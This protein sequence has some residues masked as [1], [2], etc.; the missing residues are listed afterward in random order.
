MRLFL[1]TNVLI[2]AY[3]WQGAKR[4]LLWDC[5]RGS[6]ECCISDYVVYE[7]R[8]VLIEKFSLPEESIERYISILTAFL[9]VIETSSGPKIS[10]DPKD[11][12]ILW[13][14]AKSG[15]DAL[16]TGDGDLLS[17]RDEEKLLCIENS[18]F[19]VLRT[20]EVLK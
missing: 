7:L 6:H 17:L 16:V 15:V 20:K 8:K 13:A 14:C 19:K 18:C 4:R 9:E 11:N 12:P 3:F 1:D 2:S 5:L 10:R